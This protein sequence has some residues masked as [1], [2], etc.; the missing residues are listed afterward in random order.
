MASELRRT[1]CSFAELLE[2]E[3]ATASTKGAAVAALV[4]AA[5]EIA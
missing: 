4:V 2:L 3:S 1:D 5:A